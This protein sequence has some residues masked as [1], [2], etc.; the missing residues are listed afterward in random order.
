MIVNKVLIQRIIISL[1][2]DLTVYI[3]QSREDDIQKDDFYDSLTM[4]LEC[5]GRK[6]FQLQRETLMVTGNKPEN[7][8]DQHGG[9]SYGIRKK[10]EESIHE[11]SAAINMTPE[12][13]L[14][15]K[16]VSH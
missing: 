1:T 11:F 2:S 15:K 6:K 10:E 9:Y 14:F 13:A 12:K 3:S 5:Q 7:Y 8:Q 16:S 4:S